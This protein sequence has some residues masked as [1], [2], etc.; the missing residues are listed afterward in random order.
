MSPDLWHT[1]GL[2]PRAEWKPRKKGEARADELYRENLA[3]VYRGRDRLFTVVMAIQWVF[4]VALA[5]HDRRGGSPAGVPGVPAGITIAL[6]TMLSGGVMVATTRYPGRTWTRHVVAVGQMGWSALITMLLHGRIEAHFHVFGGLALLAFYRDGRVLLTATVVATAGHLVQGA[7]WPATAYG[8]VAAT[9]LR[10]LEH[11]VW[12]VFADLGLALG[13]REQHREMRTLARRQAETE[14]LN[15]SI[16]QKV[17]RRTREL[18]ASR[19]QYRGL[20]ESTHSIPWQIDCATWGFVYVGPQAA[21][22]LGCAPA[23]WLDPDFWANR[24]HPHDRARVEEQ[25]REAAASGSH[26]EAEFRMLRADGSWV[27]VRSVASPTREGGRVTLNGF[28]IDV[29]ERHHSEEQLAAAQR[30]L[31]HAMASSSTIIYKLRIADASLQWMSDNVTRILGYDVE[32]ALAP[33]WWV[34]NIHPDDKGRLL[35]AADHLTKDD[36][37]EYRM[38][39]RN[40]EYRWIRDDQRVLLD[41]D[42]APDLIVGAFT[43]V[44]EKRYLEAELQQSQK[45]EAVG[46]LA[47]GIAHEIN[48]PVQFVTDSVVFVREAFE[49]LAP[50]RERYSQALRRCAERDPRFAEAWLELEREGIDLD[51][52]YLQEQVPKALERSLEGLERI[53]AIVRSMKEFAHPDQEEMLDADLNHALST[54]LTIARNEYKYLADV[55]T[56]FGD[57]PLVPCHVNELN[58]VFL[59]VLVN[60]ARAI[61][62]RLDG[63]EGSG[64]ITLSTRVEDGCVLVSISDD[65]CGIPESMHASIFD[66]FFT[67]KEPGRGTG[68][69]LAIARAVVVEKHGGRLTFESAIGEGTTFHIRLPIARDAVGEGEVAA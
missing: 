20:I 58:Q 11:A 10:F 21:I 30:R 54:T 38:K 48:T 12:I 26:V 62:D 37:L 68:Q 55:E 6:A 34:R 35:R 29:T 63:G 52:A 39:N 40:G 60:A 53:A 42:G 65:G 5:L 36:T 1:H 57:I 33:G 14:A 3:E 61:A 66:P 51:V 15:A 19:E 69:G 45:L 24:V 22:L 64:R 7:L 16:E 46:R 67:T 8:V 50:L 2:E 27:W 59:N 44:T 47:S 23:D 13:M 28:V 17:E 25:H 9:Q 32:E 31:K 56:D 18:E 4:G 43:D 41:G 49:D